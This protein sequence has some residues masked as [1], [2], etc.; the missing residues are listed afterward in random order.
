[1]FRL[2]PSHLFIA[3]IMV[4][5]FAIA[6][7]SKTTTTT[8]TTTPSFTW[9]ENGGAV[10]TADS[11]FWTTYSSGTGIRAY[12]GGMTNF[13]E[14]NWT[15]ANDTIVGKKTL[16]TGTF[17]DFTYINSGT[18]YTNSTAQFLNLTAFSNSKMTG[19]FDVAVTGGSVTSL[20]GSFANIEKR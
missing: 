4:C 14:I 10:I 12:R 8:T 16:N 11:A 3:A 19:D 9:Q 20:K 17:A 1:M 6:S 7:C 5:L 2:N 13:F 15:G 18:T